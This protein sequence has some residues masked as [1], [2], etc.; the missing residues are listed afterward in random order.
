L[1]LWKNSSSDFLKLMG[2]LVIPTFTYRPVIE[3]G[4]EISVAYQPGEHIADGDFSIDRI[5]LNRF[6]SGFIL[7]PDKSPKGTLN[8]TI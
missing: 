3:S 7:K 8:S 2:S 4:M 5:N 1:V 6:I